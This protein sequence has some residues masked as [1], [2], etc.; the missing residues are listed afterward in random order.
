M[1][2]D[3]ASLELAGHGLFAGGGGAGAGAGAG[4]HPG[5]GVDGSSAQHRHRLHLQ[6]AKEASSSYA[7]AHVARLQVQLKPSNPSIRILNPEP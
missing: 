6:R 1:E 4:S 2:R 3:R 5:V 7:A